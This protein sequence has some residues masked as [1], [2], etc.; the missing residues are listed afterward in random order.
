MKHLKILIITSL[1]FSPFTLLFSQEYINLARLSYNI[2]N[3]NAFDLEEGETSLKEL[4]FDLNIPIPLSEKKALL[5]GLL[6]E[7]IQLKLYNND[8][9]TTLHTVNL[10]AGVNQKFNKNW[11]VTYMLLPKFSS[12]LIK[13]K[14][15]DFQIGALALFKKH[16]RKNFN[17]KFGVFYNSDRFGPFLTPLIG[18]YYHKG[19][20]E[21]NITL[22][23][24]ADGNYSISKNGKIGLRFDGAIRSFNLNSSFEGKDQYVRRSNNEL[25]GY[26][27]W[28]MKGVNFQ[29]QVGTTIGRSYRTYEEN[30]QVDLTVSFL[31]F[32]SFDQQLNEDFSDGIFFKTTI[33]Y[34]LNL[35]SK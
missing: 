7:N 30:D 26:L 17:Y 1:I 23:A 19:K 2:S 12:D 4:S 33:L 3:D 31:K 35:A 20:W 11:D 27:Q 24:S 34:Q 8:K 10:K 22:P 5:T 9:Y 15:D 29:F 16:L 25:S 18:L 6:Y 14:K 21:T 13:W 32:G 28:N